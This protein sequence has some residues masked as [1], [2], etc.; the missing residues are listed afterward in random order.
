MRLKLD[1]NNLLDPYTMSSTRKM[2]QRIIW[3]RQRDLAIKQ[4]RRNFF[5]R[6]TKM[7]V[8]AELD[9]TPCHHLVL[10]RLGPTDTRI[11]RGYHIYMVKNG[12]F[13]RKLQKNNKS[14]LHD[15]EWLIMSKLVKKPSKLLLE[16]DPITIRASLG[17]VGR[18]A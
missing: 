9:H 11:Q 5:S 8:D 2:N 18:Q 7:C 13:L 4:S 10:G 15:K 1:A 16:R 3:L 6:V 12:R 17:Q 14:R